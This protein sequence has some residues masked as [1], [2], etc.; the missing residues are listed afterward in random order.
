MS[1][2]PHQLDDSPKKFMLIAPHVVSINSSRR[3]TQ[4]NKNAK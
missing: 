2:P 3:D 4:Q 1:V